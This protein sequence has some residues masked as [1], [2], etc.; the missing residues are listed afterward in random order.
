MRRN[1]SILLL[2]VYA[3]VFA[4]TNF[5][6]HS[7]QS[8]NGIIAHSHISLGRTAHS[9]SLGQFQLIDQLNHMP[10]EGADNIEIQEVLPIYG[11]HIEVLRDA[12]APLGHPELSFS[13]R[14]PP[15]KQ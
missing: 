9:H 10:Y 7:H 2:A 3:F 11:R 6:Y 1:I 8:A 14:A 12:A 4:S 5:F 15:C 13:L